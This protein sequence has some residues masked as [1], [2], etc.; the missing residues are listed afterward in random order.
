MLCRILPAALA[1]VALPAGAAEPLAADSSSMGFGLELAALERSLDVVA[2]GTRSSADA[3]GSAGGLY[4]YV[5][6]GAAFRAEGRLLRGSL[7]Y[8]AGGQPSSET[9]TYGEL[10]AT[11]GAAFA[12]RTRVYAGLG[13][14]QLD[15]DSPFGS[16]DGTMRSAYVPFGI[17]QAGDYAPGWRALVT[18]EGRYL[19]DG[20]DEVGGIPG[21][22]SA[23]FER[24]GGWGAAL[25]VRFRSP[26][27]DVEIQPFLTYMAPAD[28]ETENVGGTDARLEDAEHVAGGVRVTWVH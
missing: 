21:L 5:Q 22:G 19:V 6:R 15:G 13:V 17:A 4:G 3:D 18:L 24:S 10:R 16:G 8:D 2:G 23:E 25:S 11:W 27:A 26:A 1:A 28:S 7:D 12:R 20:L 9:V 14:E